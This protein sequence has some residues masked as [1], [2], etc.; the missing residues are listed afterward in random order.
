MN[1][2]RRS[3]LRDLIERL[4]P[5][6]DELESVKDEEQD[7]YDNLPDGLR[8]GMRGEMMAETVDGLQEAIEALENDVIDKIDAIAAC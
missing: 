4:N 6:R 5:I 2:Q 3:V 7:A 1:K 8:D